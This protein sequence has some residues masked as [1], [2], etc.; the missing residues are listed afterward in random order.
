MLGN[1][2]WLAVVLRFVSKVFRKVRALRRPV[3]FSLNFTHWGTIM[4]KQVRKLNHSIV[5]QKYAYMY[6][7][8]CTVLTQD[9]PRIIEGQYLPFRVQCLGNDVRIIACCLASVTLPGTTKQMNEWIN[10]RMSWLISS[11]VWRWLILVMLNVCLVFLKALISVRMS[12]NPI[13]NERNVK[14]FLFVVLGEAAMT[15]EQICSLSSEGIICAL[16]RVRRKLQCHL[17]CALSG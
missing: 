12:D 14:D 4:L 3:R 8:P 16:P 11:V 7:L 9:R 15:D 6:I 10:R 1:K 17:I 13:K 2:A 5:H